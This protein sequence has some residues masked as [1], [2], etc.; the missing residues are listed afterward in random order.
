MPKIGAFAVIFDNQKRV[1]L[2]K[3]RDCPIWNLPG[4]RVNPRETPDDAIL[5]EIKE[6]TRFEAGIQDLSG[7]Y[8]KP[9]ANEIVFCYLCQ[10]KKGVFSPTPEASEIKFF[11]INRLPKRLPDT[12]RERIKDAFSFRGKVFRK[13]QEPGSTKRLLTH[14]QLSSQK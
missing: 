1:L 3:R 9:K 8:F 4:G 13:T 2:V 10:I 5:R 6:E 11:N 7:I 12:H 14:L